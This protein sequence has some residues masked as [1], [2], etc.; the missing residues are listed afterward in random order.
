MLFGILYYGTIAW[1]GIAAPGGIYSPFIENYLDYVS[2]IKYSLMY[3]SKFYVGLF[4]IET[5]FAPE[6]VIRFV[7]GRGVLIAMDCVG[8]GV[9][10][11]WLAYT[12]ANPGT[13]KRKLLWSLGG[14]FLLWFINSLRIALFLT[15]VNKDWPMPFGLDH[16]TWFNI[17]AYLAI[18]TMM[19][20]FE[21]SQPKVQR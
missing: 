13:V 4:G 19:Y 10:S 17:F 14:V 20:F 18:F 1:I 9:Y 11:F 12:I 7:N 3:A 21:K 6:Y 2:W 8:Y 5:Y 16:H 15:A